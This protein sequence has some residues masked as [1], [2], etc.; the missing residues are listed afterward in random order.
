MGICLKIV[1]PAISFYFINDKPAISF[2]FINEKLF[3]VEAATCHGAECVSEYNEACA[4]SDFSVGDK[5]EMSE[6]KVVDMPVGFFVV[7]GKIHEPV[8]L[9]QVYGGASG[10]PAVR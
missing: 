9:R 1:K 8:V 6:N 4:G 2:Y 3:S 5:V 10:G 7:G